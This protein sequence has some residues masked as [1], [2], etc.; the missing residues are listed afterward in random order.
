MT[1]FQ[2]DLRAMQ[3]IAEALPDDDPDKIELLNNE[4]DYS[5]R[6]D[7]AIF[8]LKESQDFS[9]AIKS[10]IESYQIRQKQFN[11]KAENIKKYIGLLMDT[12]NE[13][14]YKSAAGTVSFRSTSP[15]VVIV[16]EDKIPDDYKKTTITVDKMALKKA[17]S[18]G[19]VIEGATLSNGGES[20]QVRTK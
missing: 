18:E 6:M 3:Y 9:K 12:A 8:V 5:Q 14:S 13:R 19:L 16:D 2:D 15:S 11:S 17:L 10:I 20:L 7:K 1:K 4:A